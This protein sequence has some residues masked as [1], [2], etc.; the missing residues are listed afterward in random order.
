MGF[1]NSWGDYHIFKTKTNTGPK[2]MIISAFWYSLFL[3][4]SVGDLWKLR[5]SRRASVP[6]PHFSPPPRYHSFQK[7]HMGLVSCLQELDQEDEGA[8]QHT[9]NLWS[10]SSSPDYP[11][12]V[13]SFK[14]KNNP[15]T[16]TQTPKLQKFNS[17]IVQLLWIFQKRSVAACMKSWHLCHR[18]S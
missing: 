9:A 14:N 5:T 12:R 8:S 16:Q 17:N 2:M 4:N 3:S 11:H 13:N 6:P 1:C 7:N 15:K 10:V 18:A